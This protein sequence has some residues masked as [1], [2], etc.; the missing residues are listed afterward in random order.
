MNIIA[1]CIKNKVQY[2][3]DDSD[4]L[5][6]GKVYKVKDISIGS[7]YTHVFLEGFKEG[8]NSVYFEFYEPKDIF[9]DKSFNPYL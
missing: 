5:E 8:F 9:S 2:G 7:S 1:V 6:V 4:K 3:D